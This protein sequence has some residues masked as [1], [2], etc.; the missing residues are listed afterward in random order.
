MHQNIYLW[1]LNESQFTP[2]ATLNLWQILIVPL[3]S[4]AALT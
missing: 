3:F 1:F 4:A 2:E